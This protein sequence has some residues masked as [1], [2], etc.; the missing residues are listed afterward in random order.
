MNEIRYIDEG[1]M[2]NLIGNLIDETKDRGVNH[3]TGGEGFINHLIGVGYNAENVTRAIIENCPNLK[4][5][6]NPKRARTEGFWH[7]GG[8]ITI[9]DPYHEV[10]TAWLVLNNGE[11]YGFVRDGIAT[12]RKDELKKMASSIVGEFAVGMELG[13]DF[14][15]NPMYPFYVNEDLIEKVDFLR[16][17]LSD[18][19]VPLNIRKL[20]CSDTLEKQI[21]LY[22][23]MTNNNSGNV[24]AEKRLDE[25][26][27]RYKKLGKEKEGS[28][29]DYYEKLSG[30][31]TKKKQTI[32][33]MAGVI[34][35]LVGDKL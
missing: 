16:K 27:E 14:P 12:E 30:I 11:E 22:A 32:L 28:E 1:E 20:T 33:S 31:A 24:S 35:E 17:E 34:E 9:G 23:D 25:L 6:L 5:N 3:I 18:I 15:K 13:H 2:K 26:A 10:E 29:G 4:R 7:D 8:K 19:D 21:L